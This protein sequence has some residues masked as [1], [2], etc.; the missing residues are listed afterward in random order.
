LR[1]KPYFL[2]KPEALVTAFAISNVG[3]HSSYS[4]LFLDYMYLSGFASVAYANGSL[5]VIDMRGPSVILQTQQPTHRH[6]FIPRHSANPDP[7]SSLTWAITGVKL[8]Q[9]PLCYPL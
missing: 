3:E 5:S 8:G 4:L 2:V 6:S 1:F 9:L 7:V